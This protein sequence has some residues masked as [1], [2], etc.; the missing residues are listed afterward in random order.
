MLMPGVGGWGGFSFLSHLVAILLIPFKIQLRRCV[1]DFTCH[2]S[3]FFPSHPVRNFSLKSYRSLRIICLEYCLEQNLLRQI[4]SDCN[5]KVFNINFLTI[6]QNDRDCS[7]LKGCVCGDAGSRD[8]EQV[9]NFE[10]PSH[11]S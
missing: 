6:S 1:P 2:I 4:S 8:A 7:D 5:R 3:F 10:K 9:L 11:K